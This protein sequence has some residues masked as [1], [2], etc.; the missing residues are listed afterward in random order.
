MIASLK[1]TEKIMPV[2]RLALGEEVRACLAQIHCEDVARNADGSLWVKYTGQDF[3]IIGYQG[4]EQAY[5]LI[6]TAAS[7]QGANVNFDC[8][9]LETI[10]PDGNRFEGVLPPLVS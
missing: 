3:K 1:K 4:D 7:L 9:I 6:A 10:L 5:N 2:F 8:P